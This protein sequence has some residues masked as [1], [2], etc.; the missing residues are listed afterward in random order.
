M[1]SKRSYQSRLCCISSDDYEYSPQGTYFK[2]D[3]ITRILYVLLKCILISLYFPSGKVDQGRSKR[4]AGGLGPPQYSAKKK[5]KRE[6][7]ER[8]KKEE[9]KKERKKRK[10]KTKR[11]KMRQSAKNS[12]PD[13][14]K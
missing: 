7:K 6:R 11:E 1:I 8:R 3:I 10:T 14:V 5:R 4:A 9:K 2:M 13:F 12:I